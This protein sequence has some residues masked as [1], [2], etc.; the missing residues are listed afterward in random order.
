MDLANKPDWFLAIS[1]LGKVPLL[2]I[3]Y[4]D[5]RDAVLFESAVILEYIEET[6]ESPL[7]PSDALE[8]ARDRGWIEFGSAILNG[9]ARFYSAPDDEAQTD[10]ANQLAAMFARIEAELGFPWRYERA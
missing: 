9:I 4:G 10:A 7:H 1:P 5:G 6:L 2:N 3:E 8:R